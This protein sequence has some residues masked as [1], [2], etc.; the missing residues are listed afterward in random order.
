[1]QAQADLLDGRFTSLWKVSMR[2]FLPHF[3]PLQIQ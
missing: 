2:L 1:M 3:G